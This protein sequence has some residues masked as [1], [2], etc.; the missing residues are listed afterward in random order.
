MPDF[1]DL[2]AIPQGILSQSRARPVDSGKLQLLGKQAA[3]MYSDHRVP[4]TDAVVS[5]IGKEDLGPEHT[6]RICEFANT[7]AFRNEW[8]KGGSVR[9]VE[10]TGGPADPAV[11]IRDL[12]DGSR[13]DAILVSDYSEP[14]AKIA[15]ADSRVEEEI[16]GKFAQ[17]M[18]HPSEVPSGM[19]DLHRLHQTVNGAQEH[20]HGKLSGLEV[21]KEAV[22]RDLGDT[23]CDA[24][25]R[26][27]SMFKIASAWS[28]FCDDKSLFQEAVDVSVKRM[29]Q[30]GLSD[31]VE[32]FASAAEPVGSIPNPG[33][34]LVSR[35][36]E[37]TKLA[38]QHRVLKRAVGIVGENIPSIKTALSGRS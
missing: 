33:H 36:L 15:A 7:E 8:E 13:Q 25:L 31:D 38:E 18:V 22:A 21:T 3:A 11:V 23:V 30:R 6:R 9:N 28:H 27:M 2:G 35:F 17:T 29:H 32:K 37:Y 4:L 20:I 16:F 24:I 10:F 34:P 26:G 14:P 1:K 12:N 5:V 19:G